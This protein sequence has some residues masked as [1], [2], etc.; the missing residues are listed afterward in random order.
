MGVEHL[1]RFGREFLRYLGLAALGAPGAAIQPHMFA[2]AAA[3]AA[4]W[5]WS[6]TCGRAGSATTAGTDGS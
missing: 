3:I 4:F 6:G 5:T 1:R 2:I